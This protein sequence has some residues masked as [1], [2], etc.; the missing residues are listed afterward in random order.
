MTLPFKKPLLVS[1][2]GGLQEYIKD[3]RALVKPNNVQDLYEKLM[4]VLK[5]KK[6]FTKLSKDSEDLSKELSWDTIA[7]QTVE[8]Y[9]N[10]L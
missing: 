7:D 9:R 10:L 4:H 3:K 6:L 1:D 5:D 8:A 2:V